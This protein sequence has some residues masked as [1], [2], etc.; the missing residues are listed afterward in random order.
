MEVNVGFAR[1]QE[2]VDL[3]ADL[4]V[5]FIQVGAMNKGTWHCATAARAAGIPVWEV[6]SD[7][8]SHRDP[9]PGGA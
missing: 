6:Y 7:G 1:N 8:D 4:C 2:M 5:A 9:S 3:G